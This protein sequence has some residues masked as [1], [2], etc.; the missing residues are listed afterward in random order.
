MT[1]RERCHDQRQVRQG[2]AEQVRQ[3]FN[4]E[5]HGAQLTVFVD[6]EGGVGLDELGEATKDVSAALDEID[7]IP[8][9]YTLEAYRDGVLTTLPT[10]PSQLMME[11][12]WVLPSASP[13]SSAALS[14]FMAS[15]T[16]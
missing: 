4:M 11:A 1:G 10:V 8:G 13:R 5:V 6:R 9:R 14:V 3:L 2:A 7:P 16:T 12:A 15:R